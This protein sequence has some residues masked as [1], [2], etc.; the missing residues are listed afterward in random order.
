MH[1]CSHNSQIRIQSCGIGGSRRTVGFRTGLRTAMLA[2]REGQELQPHELRLLRSDK[3]LVSVVGFGSLMSVTSARTTFPKLVNFRC[4]S[5][6]PPLLWHASSRRLVRLCQSTYS[7]A[8]LPIHCIARI[9]MQGSTVKE[10][11]KS[12]CTCRAH[13]F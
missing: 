4:V 5:S 8:H 6:C 1:F 9:S 3:G 10:L 12:L 7:L 13:I 2:V 11:E